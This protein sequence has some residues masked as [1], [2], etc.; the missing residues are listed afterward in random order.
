M[1]RI[2]TAKVSM[3]DFRGEISKIK[4]QDLAN[5]KWKFGKDLPDISNWESCI[6]DPETLAMLEGNLKELENAPQELWAQL[7]NSPGNIFYFYLLHICFV[8]G[9]STECALLIFFYCFALFLHL[10]LVL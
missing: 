5:K 8:Y 1:S 6:E 2:K 9:C 4:D 10:F 3:D 7:E